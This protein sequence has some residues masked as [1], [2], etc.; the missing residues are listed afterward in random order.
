M[1]NFISMQPLIST[2]YVGNC[3]TPP[4]ANVQTVAGR[5]GKHIEAVVLR[6][7]AFAVSAM[8]ARLPPPF[9]PLA[10]NFLWLVFH[11]L[12]PC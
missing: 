10:F 7:A 2:P 12:S 6:L 1:Q 3:V 11:V 5:I 9:L 8:Y 4:V